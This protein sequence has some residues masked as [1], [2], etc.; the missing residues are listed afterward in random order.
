MNSN[1]LTEQ[2]RDAILEQFDLQVLQQ[3]KGMERDKHSK[4]IKVMGSQTTYNFLEDVHLF[5]TKNFELKG[6]DGF[7]ETAE[8]CRI[9]S[10]NCKSNQVELADGPELS[11]RSTKK[12]KKK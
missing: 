10:V 4:P 6:D 5:K 11:K 9:Y 8:S 3:F 1:E 7:Q 2:G 12:K